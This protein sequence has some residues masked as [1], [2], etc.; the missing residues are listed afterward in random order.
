M[1]ISDHF[2]SQVYTTFI[3]MVFFYKLFVSLSLLFFFHFI[4]M[5]CIF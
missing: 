1:N 4:L 3:Y 2:K 5:K